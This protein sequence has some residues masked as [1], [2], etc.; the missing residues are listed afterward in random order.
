MTTD[1]ATRNEMRL[2]LSET[3][4]LG[5]TLSQSGFF[6]DSRGAA[7]AVTK[8]LAGRELGIPPISSMT[9]IYVIQGRISVSANILASLVKRS[10]RYNY[11]VREMTDQVCRIEFFEDGESVGFSEFTRDDAK[12]AQTKNM[13]KFPRNM[14]F[15][16][17][18]SNGVRWYCPDV[19][20]G[21]VYTPDEL[22]AS[23]NEEGDV[24][25]VPAEPQIKTTSAIGVIHDVESKPN[26]KGVMVARFYVGETLCV[27]I[28]KALPETGNAVV[29]EGVTK[30][31]DTLGTYIEVNTIEEMPAEQAA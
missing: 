28:G 20:N 8:I 1:L 15:A 25:D 18:L 3:L 11:R 14:L 27:A 7:Q 2:T 9:G 19:T 30:H 5:E 12:R 13:D 24:I 6:Q 4:T 23:V 22:G 16:R 17:A 10:K 21:P 29:V 26:N 31:H